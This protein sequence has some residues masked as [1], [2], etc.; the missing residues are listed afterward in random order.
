MAS[1]SSVHAL[2]SSAARRQLPARSMRGPSTL[3][4]ATFARRSANNAATSTSI[5]T[6]S[7]RRSAASPLGSGVAVSDR[8]GAFATEMPETPL[9]EVAACR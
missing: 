3:T 7:W 1:S 5:G 8:D 6:E 2:Q 4:T 9:P